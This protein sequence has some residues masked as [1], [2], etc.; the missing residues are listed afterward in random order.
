[1]PGYILEKNNI[2]IALCPTNSVMEKQYGIEA[3]SSSD[4]SDTTLTF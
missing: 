1:M 4:S 3:S 2:V